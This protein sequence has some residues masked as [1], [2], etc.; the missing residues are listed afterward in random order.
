[1]RFVY[2][3]NQSQA[4]N[5][6]TWPTRNHSPQ[7]LGHSTF[8]SI[9]WAEKIVNCYLFAIFY[10]KNYQIRTKRGYFVI[11]CIN[12]VQY[13]HISAITS[14]EKP[15][16][17]TARSML[18]WLRPC[19]MGVRKKELFLTALRSYAVGWKLFSYFK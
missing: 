1:V 19:W 11:V 14:S 9:P 6:V 18:C 10:H 7:N 17:V 4:Q 3:T 12:C 2:L 13:L 8:I 5:V 16:S 15:P